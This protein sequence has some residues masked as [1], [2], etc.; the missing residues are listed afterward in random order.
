MLR[1]PLVRSSRRQLAAWSLCLFTASAPAWS[2]TAEA[3][4]APPEVS[5]ELATP[6]E[7]AADAGQPPPETILVTGQR[8]GPGLWKVSKDGHVLWV[9]G[10]YR[11]LPKNMEWQSKQVETILAQSQEY[12]EPP[13]STAEVGFFSKVAMLP[14]LIGVKKNP[15]GVYLKDVV[16]ERDYAR[17]LL[18]KKKYLG[19]DDDIERERPFFAANTLFQKG[20]EQSGLTGG[21]EI[22]KKIDELVKQRGIK[23]TA[24]IVSFKVDDPVTML[25]EFK[26]TPLND[27]LCFANMLSRLEDDIDAMRVRANAWS[28]GDL[29][30]IEKLSY[31]DTRGACS[32]AV[33]ENAV[34]RSRPGTQSLQARM[35]DSW[36]A[37]AEKSLTANASTFATLPLVNLMDPKGYLAALEA[38]GY[39]VEKPE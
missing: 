4:P 8:P 16:P 27:T 12:L 3:P 37:A 30:V 6:P 9:F 2:Q 11:P 20:M 17:W 28:R 24:T 7:A 36:L 21:A 18:L 13:G 14:F 32:D 38:K 10:T 34:F 26:K 25:R 31:A 33:L 39:L 5:S 35:R 29:A 15:D 19:D 1:S 23:K 22:L